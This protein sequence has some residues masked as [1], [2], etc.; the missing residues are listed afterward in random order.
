MAD[1]SLAA[2]VFQSRPPSSPQLPPRDALL[3]ML[4]PGMLASGN[5]AAAAIGDPLTEGFPTGQAGLYDRLAMLA[6]YFGNA[7]PF[8]GG[9]VI[10]R[11]PN[12][13]PMGGGT[14]RA[15][16]SRPGGLVRQR[17][18]E[19]PEAAVTGWWGAQS[20]T[21]GLSNYELQLAAEH[22]IPPSEALE[23]WR[24]GGPRQ[25]PPVGIPRR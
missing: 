7:L 15:L 2:R 11:A 12:V 23:W 16:P 18:V 10:S 13:P 4:R 1:E 8:R 22:G 20:R 21:P 17:D 19:V 3:E 24:L 5:P 14:R 25:T 9:M 6:R